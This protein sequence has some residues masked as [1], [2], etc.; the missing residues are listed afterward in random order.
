M[1]VGGTIGFALKVYRLGQWAFR[2]VC[3]SKQIFVFSLCPIISLVR[4]TIEPEDD[5]NIILL[6]RL[7]LIAADE[8]SL[9]HD[10]AM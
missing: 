8:G 10:D 2:H 5:T 3:V 9:N 6:S 4:G 7:C 1:Y